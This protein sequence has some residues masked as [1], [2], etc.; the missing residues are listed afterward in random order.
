MSSIKDSGLADRA[1]VF[2]R[3]KEA[4]GVKDDYSALAISG[5][6][7][8][9]ATFAL[10][11]LQNLAKKNILK[12]FD[13]LS[14]VSGG[15]YIGGWLTAWKHRVKN[16]I[17][18]VSE[19]LGASRSEVPHEIKHLRSY[20]NYLSPKVGVTSFDWWALIATM[21]RNMLLNWTVFIPMLMAFLMLPRLYAASVAFPEYFLYPEIMADGTPD[22]TLPA[23][24][25]IANS[26]IVAY[27]VPLVAIVLFAIAIS[28][29]VRYLPSMG[30][31]AHTT[32]DF[33]V[34]VLVP[35]V[36][37]VWA[38]DI[39][40]N[41]HFMGSSFGQTPFIEFVI[42]AGCTYLLSLVI[43]M[44]WKVKLT[45]KPVTLLLVPFIAI[46][47]PTVVAWCTY[48]QILWS[49]T[50]RHIVGH[51]AEYVTFS[52]PLVIGGIVLGMMLF[53]GLTASVLTDEDR[54][55]FARAAGGLLLVTICWFL[56]AASVLMLPL[57]IFQFAES[58]EQSHYSVANV[59]AASGAALGW[60]LSFVGRKSHDSESVE[61]HPEMW[62][63]LLSIGLAL[64]LLILI[65]V[66][67]ILSN[68]LLVFFHHALDFI[69]VACADGSLV[70]SEKH[71]LTLDYRWQNHELLIGSSNP[72]VLVSLTVLLLLISQVFG[73]WVNT[74]IFSLQGMYRNRLVRAYLGASRDES[75]RRPNYFTGFDNADNIQLGDLDPTLRPFHVINM[76]LNLVGAKKLNWQ[77]RKAES[78]T[79]SALH[80]GNKYVG[81]RPSSK[82]G[83]ARGM[84]LGTAIATSGAAASPNMGSYSSPLL[85]FVMTLFNT[86]LGIWLGNPNSSRT[87]R[88][89][90]PKSVFVS[91]LAEALGIT[92]AKNEYIYLS[93]GGHFENLAIYEMV[94]RQCSDILI[95][96]SSMDNTELGNA[97]RK[98][99][100]D[101][102]V[103]IQF[104]PGHIAAMENRQKR[105]ALANILYSQAD[106]KAKD[107]RLIYVRPMLTGNESP[108]ILSYTI[109]SPT[110]PHESTAD[111]WFDE[112]QT[113]CYRHL[114]WSTIQD[115][116]DGFEGQGVRE[117]FEH[118][119]KNY[120][121]DVASEEMVLAEGLTP[122][123]SK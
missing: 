82:Y 65:V 48:N 54:E 103:G 36:L 28:N 114:G 117:L 121:A 109:S 99:E 14:T 55:W 5:G 9:S 120:M 13:F 83:G 111:Q 95:L 56:L 102:G 116:T 12:E 75:T 86:R 98:I 44:F 92:N 34:T 10:G 66:L 41:L 50:E 69:W 45:S 24:D 49:P 74:N 11:A 59:I 27:I 85:T 76:T 62:K 72:P 20:S 7:I 58:I 52:L 104:R 113:E 90:S 101:M 43:M 77:Q 106:D 18:E 63:F 46:L 23:L 51:W 29:V 38:L 115:M 105:C 79:A 107:G 108:A 60:F 8:R 122:A 57:L 31:K 81:Y 37:S 1:E 26:I 2:A 3:E 32:D 73:K 123:S 70:C 64:F 91:L 19:T 6:G 87:W 112:S 88:H 71:Q 53:V 35:I 21:L 97:M 93:D 40:N 22:Y 42:G 110:F 39:W 15:G 89:N 30:N 33:I 78:F 17:E 118:L 80:C 100:V 47:I 96:D 119:E 16:G 4:I 68:A 84:S 25:V 67:A 94:G 61:K